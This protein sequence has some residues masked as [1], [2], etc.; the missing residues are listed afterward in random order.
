LAANI[1]P[2]STGISL[3]LTK[4]FILDLFELSISIIFYKETSGNE[5][6]LSSLSIYLCPTRLNLAS[7]WLTI[8]DGPAKF[9]S[10][11]IFDS[12]LMLLFD[13]W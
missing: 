10:S 8:Y 2:C 13:V 7:L 9:M 12:Y 1:N 11:F 6:L 4:Y 5:I 3:L